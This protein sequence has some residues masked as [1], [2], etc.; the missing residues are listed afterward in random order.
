[1]L[2]NKLKKDK[3]VDGETI[4]QREILAIYLN[5]HNTTFSDALID[6]ILKWK[7]DSHHD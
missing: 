4:K 1:M 6:D 5:K 3:P 2:L 7:K